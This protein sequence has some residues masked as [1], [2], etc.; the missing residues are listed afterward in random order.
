MVFYPVSRVDWIRFNV[1]ITTVRAIYV[2]CILQVLLF[3]YKGGVLSEYKSFSRRIKYGQDFEYPPWAVVLGWFIAGGFVVVGLLFGAMHA[4]GT[5]DGTGCE[6]RDID[7]TPKVCQMLSWRTK[8]PSH[9]I[10]IRDIV[11]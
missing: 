7:L 3:I 4:I 2:L 11:T 8:N 6:V 9:S 1:P 5:A 10:N